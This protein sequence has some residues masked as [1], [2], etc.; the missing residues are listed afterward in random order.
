MIKS[1]VNKNGELRYLYVVMY[2]ILIGLFIMTFIKI[3]NQGILSSAF[4]SSIVFTSL[5]AIYILQAIIS[6]SIEFLALLH[7][8]LQPIIKYIDELVLVIPYVSKRENK[9]YNIDFS[10]N[11]HKKL[12]VF[13]C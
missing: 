3:M 9:Q 10:L 7:S 11:T 1:P 5:L 8:I 12:C 4:D 2:S 6:V 13:R